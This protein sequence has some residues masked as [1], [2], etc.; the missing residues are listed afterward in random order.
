MLELNIPDP[1]VH[2]PKC[3]FVYPLDKTWCKAPHTEP[4][5][6]RETCCCVGKRVRHLWGNLGKEMIILNYVRSNL[7]LSGMLVLTPE[8]KKVPYFR[9][10]DCY[11]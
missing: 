8:V 10:C 2:W 4:P 3:F 9:T 11:I 1:V 7:S 5:S 6:R